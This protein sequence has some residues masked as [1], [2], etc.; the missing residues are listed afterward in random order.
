MFFFLFCV[1]G[2]I[3]DLWLVIQHLSKIFGQRGKE[4]RVFGHRFSKSTIK[5]GFF[6]TGLPSRYHPKTC[7]TNCQLV[8]PK[9]V[10]FIKN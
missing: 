4:F 9:N 1:I 7:F 5:I 10:Y 2:P 6:E 3:S 8:T